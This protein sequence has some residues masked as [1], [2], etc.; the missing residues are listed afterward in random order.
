MLVR[1][2]RLSLGEGGT[3]AGC[4]S[5]KPF[6]LLAGIFWAFSSLLN[7]ACMIVQMKTIKDNHW[8]TTHMAMLQNIS[9]LCP[10]KNIKRI[11]LNNKDWFWAAFF[12]QYFESKNCFRYTCCFNHFCFGYLKFQINFAL[13]TWCFPLVGLKSSQQW[14]NVNLIAWEDAK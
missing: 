13:V 11:T 8:K 12:L 4:V 6:F 3:S 9:K 10:L 7:C 1:V 14:Q 5:L 2:V